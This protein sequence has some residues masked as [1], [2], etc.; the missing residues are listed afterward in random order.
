MCIECVCVCVFVF[1]CVCVCVRVCVYV[2]VYV[3][4]HV[5]VCVHIGLCVSSYVRTYMCAHVCLSNCVRMYIYCIVGF[6]FKVLKFH[7]CPV[8]SYFMILFSQMGLP[9]WAIIW[10]NYFLKGLHFTNDPHLRNSQN[11][12]TLIKPT[13]R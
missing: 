3:C 9:K 1:V 5:S 4:V 13:I 2:C 6:L 12:H 7:K 10:S 8:F 11:L